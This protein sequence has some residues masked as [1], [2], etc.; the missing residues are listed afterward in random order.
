MR[1][2][3]DYFLK[4][5]FLFTLISDLILA[6][7]HTAPIGVLTFSLAQL[8]HFLRLKPNNIFPKIFLPITIMTLLLGLLFDNLIIYAVVYAITE[9]INFILAFRFN[10]Q[11]VWGFGLFLTCDLCVAIGFLLPDFTIV[12]GY[13]CW[14]FYLPSQFLLATSQK[15]VVK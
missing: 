3:K 12:M 14:L 6:Q 2:K 13:I 1:P 7:N 10:K 8:A 4:I 15:T 5:A 11:L 9:V